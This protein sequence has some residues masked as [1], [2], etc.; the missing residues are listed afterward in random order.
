MF[1]TAEGVVQELVAAESE[2]EDAALGD[3][4]AEENGGDADHGFDDPAED[5]AV[6][7]R[8]EIEG[9]EAAKECGGLALV[10]ELDKFNVSEDFG[11]A[12]IARKEKNGHH[13]A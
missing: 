10:A 5:E 7:Q 6:H 3:G 13:A 11:A 12:P 2:L 9:A 8:A 4:V 1:R